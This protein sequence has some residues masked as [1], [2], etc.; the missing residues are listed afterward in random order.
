MPLLGSAT[1]LLS[2]DIEQDAIRE[3]DDW[4]THEHLPERLSIPGFLRGTRW[5]AIRGQPRYLVMYEVQEL[6]TLVSDAYLQRL[7]HPT[8]WTAKMMPYYR[9]MARGLCSVVTSLGKGL[10]HFGL[11]TRFSPAPAMESFLTPWLTEDL[12]PNLPSRPGLGSVH[13]FKGAAVPE[14]TNEQRL[15]G[16]DAGVVYAL[17]TTGYDKLSVAAL[18]DTE[19]SQAKLGDRGALGATSALYRTEY[20]L[21]AQEIE[22]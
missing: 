14:M 7:N 10:G 11:L 4:H 21:I 15:R 3:H 6:G 1:L 19:L 22:T 20:T 5:G 16:V 9:G 8:P 2:F 17:L 13:L 18:A 12:L